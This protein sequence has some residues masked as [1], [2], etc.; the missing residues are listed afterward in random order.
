MASSVPGVARLIGLALFAVACTTGSGAS[1]IPPSPTATVQ[2]APTAP[3]EP[4]ATPRTVVPG[5]WTATPDMVEDRRYHT[6]TRLLD[7]RVLVA[8]GVVASS[9]GSVDPSTSAELYDP[10]AGTWA[11]TGSMHERRF[12]HTAT[13]LTDGRVLVTGGM[14]GLIDAPSS[15]SAELYDPVSGTWT[16]TANMAAGRA[17]HAAALLADGRVLVASGTTAELYDPIRATWTATGAMAGTQAFGHAATLLADG[18]VLVAGNGAGE[19]TADAEIYDPG[20]GTWHATGSLIEARD[21]QTATLLSNGTVLVAGGADETGVATAS[22]EL[23]DPLGGTWTATE[24]MVTQ[25]QYQAAVLLPDGRVLV[26][27]NSWEHPDAS[28][29]IYD[30]ADGRWN[31]TTGMIDARSGHTATLLM[32]G[33]VLVAGG[34]GLRSAELFD[35]AAVSLRRPEH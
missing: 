29:E 5:T 10:A 18:R 11:A 3:T 20:S 14:D 24:P 7:G 25:A 32:D 26:A 22:A 33:T 13:L 2:P 34:G 12:D 19:P 6:A 27:G 15:R 9:D 8:G 35:P 16:A 28:A 31:A 21:G 17:A 4:T 1:P 23:Y 30:P